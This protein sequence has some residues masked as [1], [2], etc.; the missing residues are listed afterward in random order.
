[1]SSFLLNS[2][3]TVRCAHAGQVLPPIPNPRVKVGGLPIVTQGPPY[4]ISGCTNLP[5]AGSVGP[6]ILA[7][8]VSASTRVKVMGRPV[9]LQNST[10][11]CIPTGLPVS[12]L[13]TQT[14]VRGI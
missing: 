5:G 13:I 7:Q 10:A 11:V 14:R 8:W 12:I 3:S 6:C 1:M 2:L 9:L 4:T